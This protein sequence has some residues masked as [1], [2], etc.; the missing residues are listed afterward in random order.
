MLVHAWWSVAVLCWLFS[1]LLKVIEG[2]VFHLNYRGSFRAEKWEH[3]REAALAL[4]LFILFWPFW[5]LWKLLTMWA[6]SSDPNGP[7]K[8]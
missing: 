5:L 1:R 2:T 8:K 7:E 6:D 3:W 4:P